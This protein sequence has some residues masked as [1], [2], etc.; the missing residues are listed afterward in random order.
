[1]S[2]A[3]EGLPRN[4]NTVSQYREARQDELL[5]RIGYSSVCNGSIKSPEETT[6][7]IDQ[8]S[9]KKYC[10]VMAENFWLHNKREQWKCGHMRWKLYLIE[11]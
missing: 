1:V 4:L 3:R 11:Q 2:L 7:Q 5:L 8:I 6:D 10:F 9:Q